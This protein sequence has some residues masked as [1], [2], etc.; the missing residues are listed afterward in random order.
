MSEQEELEKIQKDLK[1]TII[2][3]YDPPTTRLKR[4]YTDRADWYFLWSL[5]ND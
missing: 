4:N 5:E 2:G 1:K 3:F